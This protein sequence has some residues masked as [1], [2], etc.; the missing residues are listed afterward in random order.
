MKPD[1]IAA[2]DT[3]RSA[4]HPRFTRWAAWDG[5]CETW[6]QFRLAW[7]TIPVGAKGKFA[8]TI[9]VGVVLCSILTAG[10][11]L[12]AKW[13]APHGLDAWDERVL[14]GLDAR[15]TLSIQE[16]I[17]AESFGN[18]AYMIPLVALCAIV[19]ARRRRPLLAIAFVAAYVLARGVVWVGWLIW[20]RQRPTFILEGKAA[21]PLN[22][23]PSGHVALALS[24]YGILVYLWLRASKSWAERVFAVV[25]LVALVALTGIARVRLGTHWPTDVIAGFVIGVAWLAA[26]LRALH[27]AGDRA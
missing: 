17:I 25:V 21:P 16:A 11:T 13:R 9:G 24:V 19:A 10:L 22:S 14:R 18:M 26:V 15:D 2:A 6:R 23:F 20:E 1:A 5:W 12:L 8:F 7:I 3:G 27:Q 4:S